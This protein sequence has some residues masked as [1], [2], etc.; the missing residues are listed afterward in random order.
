MFQSSYF[1]QDEEFQRGEVHQ[2]NILYKIKNPLKNIVEDK[3]KDCEDQVD[4]DT[5]ENIRLAKI[6]SKVMRK[7]NMRYGN[8][9]STNVQENRQHNFKR[10]IFQRKGIGGE[11]INWSNVLIAKILDIFK[12]NAQVHQGNKEKSI[13]PLMMMKVNLIKQTM[14]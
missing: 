11:N 3:Y 10:C 4:Y 13:I 7:L 1:V 14:L 6:F 5:K 8:N 12:M 9:V 2:P